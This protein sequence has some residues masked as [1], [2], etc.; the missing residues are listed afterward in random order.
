VCVRHQPRCS[1]RGKGKALAPRARGLGWLDRKEHQTLIAE[2]GE[3]GSGGVVFIGEE[4]LTDIFLFFLP[5]DHRNENE[6]AGGPL[7]A[8]GSCKAPGIP[9]L[10]PPPGRSRRHPLAAEWSAELCI[11][12]LLKPASNHAAHPGIRV[13]PAQRPIGKRPYINIKS[14]RFCCFVMKTPC[15]LRF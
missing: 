11:S 4:I 6:R 13:E 15:K 3:G 1:A 7:A 12:Y 10:A 14:S 9:G 5:T 8:S 2:G